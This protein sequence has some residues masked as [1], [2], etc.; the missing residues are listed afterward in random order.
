VFDDIR[1]AYTQNRSQFYLD[2]TLPGT[3]GPARR[4]RKVSGNTGG[5]KA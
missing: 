5:C 3:T 1:A 2:L 4:F